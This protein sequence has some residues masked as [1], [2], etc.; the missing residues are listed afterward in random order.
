MAAKDKPCEIYTKICDLY[1]EACF[2]Q[3]KKITK[4]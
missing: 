4:G 1:G 3:K 2:L